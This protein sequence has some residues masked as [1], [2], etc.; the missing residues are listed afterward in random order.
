MVTMH[1]SD[2]IPPASAHPLIAPLI[3]K[4]ERPPPLSPQRVR[5]LKAEIKQLL[6]QEDAVIVAH[7]YTDNLIKSLALESGGIVA[8][9][10][11][12]A[13]FGNTH[14]A[15]TLMVVGV[16]FMGETA[17]I[18]SPDKRVLVPDL[19]ATCSL[20]VGCPADEFVEFIA[21][22]PN[23][24]VVSYANTSAAVKA[25]SDWVVTSSIALDVVDYLDGQGEE[26][27]WAPDRHLGSYIARKT[28]VDMVCWPGACIV[29]EEFKA[30]AILALQHT[31]PGSKILA[32]P[33]A[34]ATVLEIADIV[35]STSQLL[36]AAHRLRC[37]RFIVAT[38]RGL[39]NT[40]KHELPEKEF[41]A[42]P[43]AGEGATCKSCASCPWMAMNSLEKLAASLQQGSS[44]ITIGSEIIERAIVPL[45]RMLDF[46]VA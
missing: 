29:H 25:L 44:E 3:N 4:A 5:R 17:K 16:R 42:A 23:R 43:T 20:D 27:L 22:H 26:I 18:L 1:L 39:L 33:E 6:R 14:K 24:T 7:Y 31:L 10:L 12:M 46:A 41:I 19:E 35:G 38:D 13:R 21:Q 40:M 36:S 34:P 32:H 2:K 9:S 8:D 15:S 37:Q 11:E 45:H 30:H 28:G